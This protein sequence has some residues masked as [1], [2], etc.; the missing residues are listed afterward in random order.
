[1]EIA[2]K[3]GKHVNVVTD[4]DGNLEAIKTKYEKYLGT[5]APKYIKI[6]FDETIDTG[7]LKIGNKNF[8]YNTLEPKFL[9]TNGLEKLNT[10]FGTT[11]GT[12]DEMHKYMKVNKTE[13][14]LKIFDTASNLKFPQYILDSI[15]DDE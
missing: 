4:N 10:I 1:M 14:A 3:I 2:E 7:E 5:N 8:N 9:K 6:C 15:S 11:Y 13:C 12:N